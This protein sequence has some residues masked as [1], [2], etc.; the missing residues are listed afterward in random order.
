M[1]DDQALLP[2]RASAEAVRA[3]GGGSTGTAESVRN[4]A[5]PA[6]WS[7]SRYDH[8]TAVNKGDR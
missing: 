5:D 1:V 3:S 2:C 6:L 4:W 8:S 7:G